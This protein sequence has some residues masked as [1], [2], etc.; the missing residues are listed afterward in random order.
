MRRSVHFERAG[1]AAWLFA[2]LPLAVFA[3]PA[4]V[5]EGGRWVETLT[6]SVPA[7]VRL[8]A[9]C[10]GPVH[11]EAGAAGDGNY[12]VRLSVAARTE[13]EARRILERS[14]VRVSSGE[15]AVIS[16]GMGRPVEVQL[17]T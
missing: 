8:R 14:I 1:L 16:P 17:Q 6:G 3:Q 12:T 15:L 2:A 5:R 9:S 13:A 7:G 4:L 11:L 10:Q